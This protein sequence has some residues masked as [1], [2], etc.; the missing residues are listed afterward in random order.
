[1]RK[2]KTRYKEKGK[3]RKKRKKILKKSENENRYFEEYPIRYRLASNRLYC[4]IG[5]YSIS[6]EKPHC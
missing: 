3:K 6:L 4:E 1:M 5:S 2:K